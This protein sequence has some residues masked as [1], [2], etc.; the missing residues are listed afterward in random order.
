[1]LGTEELFLIATAGSWPANSAPRFRCR[2]SPALPLVLPGAAH[3]LRALVERRAAEVGL[4]LSVTFEVDSTYT[5]KRLVAAGEG[6]SILSAHAVREEVANGIL[7]AIPIGPPGIP[8]MVQLA[9]AKGR[10]TDPSVTAVAGII[11]DVIGPAL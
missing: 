5:I 7:A 2:R 11:R 6:C 3:G 1:M 9:T 4:V 8:R 10:Q